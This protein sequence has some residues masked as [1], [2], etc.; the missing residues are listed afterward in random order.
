[1]SGFTRDWGTLREP[2]KGIKN[3]DGRPDTDNHPD[4]GARGPSRSILSRTPIPLCW[5]LTYLISCC[6]TLQPDW[7]TATVSAF[8]VA[9]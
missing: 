3:S 5:R 6:A 7:N 9:Y 2:T 8:V 1:M 4:N